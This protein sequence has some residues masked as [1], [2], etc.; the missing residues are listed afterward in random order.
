[1]KGKKVGKNVMET[2]AD[3]EFVSSLYF[4]CCTQEMYCRGLTLLIRIEH[5]NSWIKHTGNRNL[6]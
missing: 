5:Y 4:A 2:R 6:L 3:F 1:M